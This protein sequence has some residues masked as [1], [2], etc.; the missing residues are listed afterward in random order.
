MVTQK[1]ID[2]LENL[3]ANCKAYHGELHDHSKS[4][5]RSDG[6]CTLGELYWDLK[7]L[8]MDFTTILDHHQVRHM[9]LPEWKEGMFI[10]GSEPGTAIIDSKAENKGLHYNMIFAHPKG[11]EDLLLQFTEFGFT[12]GWDGL[13][14]YPKF[15]R[16]RFCELIDT[17]KANGGFFVQPHPKQVMVSDDPLDYWYRDETGI[18]VFYVTMDSEYT[19]ANYPLWRD[20]L[21]LGKRVWACA[22]GDKHRHVI[23][24]A[25]TTIY[26]EEYAAQSYLDHLRVGD[27]TC[28][29]MGIRMCIGDTKTGGKCSFNGQKLIISVGDFHCSVQDP[30]H[31]YR[32][33]IFADDEVIRSE[34][35]DCYDKTYLVMDT[36]DAVK[37]YRVEVFDVTRDLRIGIGNPIWNE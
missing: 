22:G 29:P 30:T 5:G 1:N 4:G 24:T 10:G 31:E 27:F 2:Q 32:M 36:D 23:D 16:E 14:T 20:L 8:K 25:L 37:Y 35:I 7:S 33:D 11:L 21:R 26:A 18:E 13:F 6:K 3:Y 34:M 9:Y 15:T 28:G 17:V 19:D 12:G